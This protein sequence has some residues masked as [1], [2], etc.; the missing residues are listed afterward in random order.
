MNAILK[1]NLL[2]KKDKDNYR[3]KDLCIEVPSNCVYG[4][5][6]PNGAGKTTTLKLVLGLIGN[7][8]GE[9]E[10]FGQKITRGNRMSLLRRT[11]SLIES[12]AFYGHLTGWEN[13]EIFAKYKKVGQKEAEDALREVKLWDSRDKKVEHYSLGMKQRLGIAIALLGSPELLILDEPTNGLDPSGIHEIR[14][15]LKSLPKTRNISV[16]VS[17]HLLGEIEQMADQVGIISHGQMLYQGPLSELKKGDKNL[18]EVFLQM[19]ESEN[20]SL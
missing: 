6:G 1:T 12:P 4:F 8:G 20:S 16:L 9:V 14:E 18:E 11:G 10:L 17:S 3:V 2:S 19:T 15:L 5:L 7:D 13:I